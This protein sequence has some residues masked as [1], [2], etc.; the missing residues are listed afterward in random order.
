MAFVFLFLCIFQGVGEGGMV[1]VAPV[2][3]PP[4]EQGN[5]FLNF[6]FVRLFVCFLFSGGQF[7]PNILKSIAS[8][9]KSKI[10]HFPSSAKQHREMTK[11]HI[12]NTNRNG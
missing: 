8:K 5:L 3:L 9:I 1:E 7:L 11:F 12:E 10:Y 2:G 6:L 4:P